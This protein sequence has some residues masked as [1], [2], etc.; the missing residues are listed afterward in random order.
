MHNNEDEHTNLQLS[1]TKGRSRAQE[2]AEFAAKLG[3]VEISRMQHAPVSIPATIPPATP[4]AV[5]VNIIM[6]SLPAKPFVR[7][8]PYH[9]IGQ[10]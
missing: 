2:L 9:H 3:T 6:W 5:A 8:R 1:F 7:A 4:D 10:L